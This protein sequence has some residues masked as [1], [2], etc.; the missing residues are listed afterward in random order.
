MIGIMLPRDDYTPISEFNSK[1]ERQKYFKQCK[2][3]CN[4]NVRLPRQSYDVEISVHT[5]WCECS[6]GIYSKKPVISRVSWQSESSIYIKNQRISGALMGIPLLECPLLSRNI[7]YA[8]LSA[9]CILTL[10]FAH[11]IIKH[12]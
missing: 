11:N 10:Y 2:V 6:Y 7:Q 8:H 4:K 1:L 3:P 9:Y 12:Y 5:I